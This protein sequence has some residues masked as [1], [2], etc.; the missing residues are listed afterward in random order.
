MSD[1]S[2]KPMATVA[3][4]LLSVS[5]AALDFVFPWTCQLCGCSDEV[6]R[7]GVTGN[8]CSECRGQIAPEIL[9]SCRRCG[10]VLGPHSSAPG[11]CVHCRNKPIR[12][13]SLT[14]LGMYE[15]ALRKAVLSAKW[16]FSSAGTASLADLLFRERCAELRDFDADVVIPIP[17]SW[18]VR[19]RRRFNPAG[20]IATVLATELRVRADEHILRRRRNTR[21]QKRVAVQRRFDNQ[22]NSFRVRDGHLVDGRRILL[23]DDVVTTGAT[24]SEAT[25][26]LKKRGAKCC[27]VAVLARVLDGR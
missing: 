14:C 6:S 13:D 5:Q 16:S 4:T 9:N 12:F 19:L 24:C 8:F 25:R 1:A 10:A 23:V 21:P 18:Q 17:Q 26:M 7:G 20:V 22:K 3:R 11:G 27:A 2:R 15:D